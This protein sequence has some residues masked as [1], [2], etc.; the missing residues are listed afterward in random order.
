VVV[1]GLSLDDQGKPTSGTIPDDFAEEG[2]YFWPNHRVD[3]GNDRLTVTKVDPI[4]LPGRRK[5]AWLDYKRREITLDGDRRVVT[6]E[7]L[8]FKIPQ[9]SS[10]DVNTIKASYRRLK[11]QSEPRD[12]G[13]VETLLGQV[14]LW[15][16]HDPGE[17]VDA[18]DAFRATFHPDG[19]LG[20]L[21]PRTARCIRRSPG[22]L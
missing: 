10:G 6:P 21:N 17:G 15:A 19:F 13:K 7:R 18:L 14:F 1:Q 2:G 16:L 22:D 9:L 3:C 20:E 5:V 11:R 8:V 12:M 4:L